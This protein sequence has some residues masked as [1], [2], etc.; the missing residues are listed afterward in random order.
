VRADP[1]GDPRHRQQHAADQRDEQTPLQ[2]LGSFGACFAK[3]AILIR[4]AGNGQFRHASTHSVGN[5][6]MPG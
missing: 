6:A 3:F 5:P 1:S 2:A 4:G